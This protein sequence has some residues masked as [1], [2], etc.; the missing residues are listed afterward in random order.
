MVCFQMILRTG[1]KTTGDTF[2]YKTKDLVLVY[3]RYHILSM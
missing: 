3:D 2:E 1:S